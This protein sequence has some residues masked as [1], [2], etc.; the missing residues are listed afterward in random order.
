MEPQTDPVGALAKR[1]RRKKGHK[2]ARQ[3]KSTAGDY[4]AKKELAAVPKGKKM[5][6]I[7]ERRD[8]AEM[9]KKDKNMAADAKVHKVS[10]ELEPVAKEI[11]VKFKLATQ[12]DGKA[13]DH[14]LSAALLL[15]SARRRCKE[16]KI[17]FGKWCEKYV[18]KSYDEVRKLVA[19][20]SAPEPAKAL[21]DMRAGAAARNRAMRG[22]QKVS[23]DAT[24]PTSR[25]ETAC[26]AADALV[27]H[28]PDK[29][30]LSLITRR[31][32]PLGMAVVSETDKNRLSRIDQ[33]EPTDAFV[34][35]EQVFA[36]FLSQKAKDQL[37]LVEQMAEHIGGKFKHDFDA[38]D[39]GIPKK[40]QRKL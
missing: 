4:K 24:A 37:T 5:G 30:A 18:D 29:E 8:K 20:A 19:V 32:A 15:E 27:E 1:T 31:A 33:A 7:A 40:M 36:M 9:A 14:R 34:R 17:P 3:T 39:P 22:R 28:L 6:A 23:R 26:E 35:P 11:N 25:S 13:D 16:V 2:T 10:K 12:L 38:D 21:A